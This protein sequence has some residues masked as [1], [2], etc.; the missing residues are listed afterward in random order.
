MIIISNSLIRTEREADGTRYEVERHRKRCGGGGERKE[1]KRK[2]KNER[3]T[4][5]S[6]K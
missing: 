6:V 4:R 5:L 3:E 1:E 2:V